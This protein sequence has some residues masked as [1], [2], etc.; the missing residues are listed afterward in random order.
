[1]T[2]L[3]PDQS[4][5]MLPE[6][7]SSGMPPVDDPSRSN[8][9]RIVTHAFVGDA[10]CNTTVAVAKVTAEHLEKIEERLSVLE[11][12]FSG[13]A[14]SSPELHPMECSSQGHATRGTRALAHA[15]I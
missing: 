15:P 12:S 2:A 1:M 10:I 9:D 13:G 3:P 7:D 11:Q 14:S 5:S 4:E 6:R 8:L